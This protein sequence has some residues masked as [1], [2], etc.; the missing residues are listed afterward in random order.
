MKIE[1]CGLLFLLIDFV[2][3]TVSSVQEK[4][5]KKIKFI[6]GEETVPIPDVAKR[7]SPLVF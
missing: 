7:L 4:N 6:E 5:L 1:D 3:L 2:H